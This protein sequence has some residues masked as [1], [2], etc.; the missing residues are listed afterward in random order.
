MVASV[1]NLVAEAKKFTLGFSL[2]WF[3][4]SNKFDHSYISIAAAWQTGQSVA[5]NCTAVHG[6]SNGDEELLSNNIE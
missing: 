3:V 5:I 6:W 4:G 2:V 1:F